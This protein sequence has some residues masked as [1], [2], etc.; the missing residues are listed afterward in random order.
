MLKTSKLGTGGDQV[1]QSEYAQALE[2]ISNRLT[3]LENRPAINAISD[4]PDG[5]RGAAEGVAASEKSVGSV[6]AKLD[7]TMRRPS[8]YSIAGPASALAS[9]PGSS[10]ANMV[11]VGG[12]AGRLYAETSGG[13]CVFLGTYAGR[14]LVS[15]GSNTLVGQGTGYTMATGS[16]NVMLGN[17]AGYSV[18]ESQ[19][20]V[21]LG[22]QAGR[23]LVDN[24]EAATFTNVVALGYNSKVSGNNEVQ[25]GNTTQTV[26]TQQALQTRS[27]KRDKTDIQDSVLGLDF[28]LALRPVDFRWDMREDYLVDEYD[29]ISG[30]PRMVAADRD[31]SKKRKRL[32]H[33][34]IAQEVKGAMDTLGVDFGGYQD[35]SINGG[36]DVLS[37]G[38]QEFT[39][40][41]IKAVQQLAGTVQELA[42]KIAL[43]EN[44]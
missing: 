35:H 2:N 9:L 17:G 28:I 22:A 42:E 7:E 8:A 15:G 11:A 39:G 3:R 4:A 14:S 44:R 32:H 26:Y 31:G 13:H 38:Y 43:L 41:L 10:T 12:E 19:Q 23:Y 5:A 16:N 29:D 20:S 27:D 36:C 30:V 34:L 37:L 40:P 1:A 33:G 18:S 25:I 24:T 21:L 6:S